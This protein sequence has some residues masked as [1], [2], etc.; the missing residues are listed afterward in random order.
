M[1]F[2]ENTTRLRGAHRFKLRFIQPFAVILVSAIFIILILTMGLIDMRRSE[3]MLSGFI[4]DQGRRVIG[5]VEKLTEENLKNMIAASQKTPGSVT[6]SLKEPIFSPDTLLTEKIIAMGREIDN[7]WKKEHISGSYISE[8]AR[9]K[10]IWLVAVLNAAGNVIFQSRPVAENLRADVQEKKNIKQSAAKLIKGLNT[11]NRQKKIGFIAMSRRDE[12]GTIILALDRESMRY[13]GMRVS[14]E[15]A[16]EKLGKGQGLLYLDISDDKGHD[17]GSI[18]YMP[19]EVGLDDSLRSGILSGSRRFESRKTSRGENSVQEITAPFYLGKEIL[20]VIIL[21]LDR[22]N[23]DKILMENRRNVYLFL[24]FVIAITLLSLWLLYHNQNR[25]LGRVVEMTRQLE[26]AERLSSLG[27]LAAGVAHE[28]RNPLNA[29][30]MASQRLKREFP[31]S[32]LG[33]KE[34]F[35]TITTVIRDEIRRLNGIIEEFLTFSKSR[36]LELRESAVQDVLRKI[37]NL[38]SA[39]ASAKGVSIR[40]DWPEEPIVIPMDMDKLQQALLNFVKNAVESIS[41]AGDVT[42]AIL[43][44]EKGL[45]NIIITDT[46]CGLTPEEVER[47]FNPEYT[48][49]EKGLGLGL[50]LAHEIIRG[51]GGE[52]R[53][54][55]QKGEGTVFEIF[56]PTERLNE[57]AAAK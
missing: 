57:K 41:G 18:G 52:I 15:R 19:G 50:S 24:V 54:K 31:P 22:G 44:E 45:V 26:K 55:S 11:L 32:E 34:E 23:T 42:L 43:N 20:G 49:K 2:E 5:V 12:S 47:I 40:T 33:K 38:V 8:F 4:E 3:R 37:V 7:H 53:V 36:R 30:S 51:H 21:G 16:I 17:L 6:I 13:W 9:K 28:I 56:M 10:N 39:E 48:T 1:N 35:D 25:H 29:I 27:M 46:G 14:V